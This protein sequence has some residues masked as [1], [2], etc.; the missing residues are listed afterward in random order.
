MLPGEMLTTNN[1]IVERKRELIN[2]AG[3]GNVELVKECLD[4]GRNVNCSLRD[5]RTPLHAAVENGH[6]EVVELLLNRKAD[7]K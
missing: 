3:D 2:A 4:Q 5:G 1:P 6:M 7:I